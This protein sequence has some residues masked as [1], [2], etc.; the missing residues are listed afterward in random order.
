MYIYLRVYKHTA[1]DKPRVR[2]KTTKGSIHITRVFW[3]WD[4]LFSLN[5]AYIHTGLKATRLHA[6]FSLV[7]TYFP[8]EKPW[9]VSVRSV[10]QLSDIYFNISSWRKKMTHS[11]HSEGP[12]SERCYGVYSKKWKHRWETARSHTNFLCDLCRITSSLCVSDFH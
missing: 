12:A 2:I 10:L 8:T 9:L 4:H 11:S 3:R 6:S 1:P 7:V 5:S